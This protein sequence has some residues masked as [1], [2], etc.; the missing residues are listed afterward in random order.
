VQLDA[1]WRGIAYIG[2][3][4]IGSDDASITN[5]STSIMRKVV[6][7]LTADNGQMTNA[8]YPTLTP[9]ETENLPMSTKSEA[10][11]AVA[12]FTIDDVRWRLT[13]GGALKRLRR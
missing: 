6:V 5:H 13:S 10:P 4:R 7:T 11:T 2:D 3:E 8:T 9:G 12:E 1:R